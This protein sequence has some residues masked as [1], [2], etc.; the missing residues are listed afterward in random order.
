MSCW[1]SSTSLTRQFDAAAE[2][3][4][5]EQ[6]RTLHNGYLASCGL[7]VPR[8][9]NVRRTVDFAIEM[10]RIIDR[11]NIETGHDLKLRAGIDTGTVTSGL[12]GRTTLA[13]DMW[14]SAV[15]LAYQVQSGS[16]QPG[17]YVDVGGVRSDARQPQL[18]V[19]G[20][21][22]RR[23]G[24]AADLAADGAAIMSS[25]ARCAVV[26]LG[27]RRGDRL[28]DLP[29]AAD[30][31]AQQLCAR[32]GSILARP[33]H[34]VRNYILPL[35]ALLI[36]LVKGMQISARRHRCASWRRCSVSSCWC[37]CS[38]ALNATLF[39][40]APE[41]SWRKRIPSIFLDVA[42]FA[43][44]AVGVG[45]ISRL[46]LGRRRR[47]AVH[48]AG[49]LVDRARAD[50]AELR[51][52]DHLGPARVVRAAVP[53]RRLDRNADGAW[54]RRRSQLARNTYRHRQRSADHAQLGTGRRVL[55]Q[56]SAVR[57]GA[58]S[59]SVTT[60]FAVDD[61]ARRRLRDAEPGGG[62]LPQLRPDA[63]PS[64]SPAGGRCSTRR[65]S[66]CAR[67][68]TT[69]PPRSM[70]LRW[71]WYASRRAGLHLDEAEDEFATPERLETVIRIIAPTLRLN[72]ADQ[73]QLLAHARSPDTAPTRT[74]QFAGQVPKRMTFIVRRAGAAGRQRR[75]RRDR[76]RPNPGARATFWARPPSPGSPSRRPA[77]AL[78]EVTVLQI[79]REHIEELV[80]AKAVAVAGHRPRHRGAPGQAC[81]GRWPPRPN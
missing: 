56:L 18:R 51:R 70:F 41:G 77:Y 27:H 30:R 52:A 44:I 68:P 32:R 50:A 12:V 37:C 42:R 25:A 64:S 22:H 45:L 24:R 16:P 49:C 34:L 55:H 79:D 62:A 33:V 81:G 2:N 4:G 43:L 80:G 5:V 53:A 28:S 61:P 19:C 17:V 59:L 67:P 6:V 35:G 57:P 36:L 66:R 46:H 21:D 71:V 54:P 39:Q 11:F 1:R 58:H 14:G 29:G 65:R 76:S 10:Q 69:S 63:A 15:N 47:R 38:P 26:L 60:V 48:R 3:L 20:D 13:Y 7:S 40:G 31:A 78:G 73:E 23:R 8:L 9:D 72:Q 74:L 75:R